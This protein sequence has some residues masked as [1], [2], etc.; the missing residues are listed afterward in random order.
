[1]TVAEDALTEGH[2]TALVRRFYE[3]ALADASLRPIFEAT[4]QDWE[5]HHRVVEDF[6]SRMLLHTDRYRGSPYP[7]HAR[8]PIRPEHFDR[9]LA[10]FREAA[11]ETLPPRAAERAIACSEHMAEA[12]KAGMFHG[13][14][15]P[16]KPSLG[17]PVR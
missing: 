9:W 8:L 2:I 6:W 7:V 3:R 11:L 5:A 15:T 17:Y 10:L 12:F 16:I 1:M 13:L 14:E 4:I